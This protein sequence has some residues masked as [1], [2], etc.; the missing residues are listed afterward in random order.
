MY[1]FRKRSPTGLLA[2]CGTAIVFP[3]RAAA[4]ADMRI[5]GGAKAKTAMQQC[6]ARC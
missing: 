6:M 3:D 4:V 2:F 1:V 5:E